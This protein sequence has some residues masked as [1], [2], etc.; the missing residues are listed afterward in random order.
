MLTS[1]SQYVPL[2]DKLAGRGVMDGGGNSDSLQER[3]LRKQFLAGTLSE[4]DQTSYTER[5]G[6]PKLNQEREHA[7]EREFQTELQRRREASGDK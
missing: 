5:F 4:A 2:A 7:R 6:D 3:H 1:N